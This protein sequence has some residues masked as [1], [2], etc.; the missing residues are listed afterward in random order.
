MAAISQMSIGPGAFD[1]FLYAPV[2]EDKAGID[3]T[4]LSA[5]A[6][7][8]LDPWSEAARLAEL[9]RAAAIQALTRSIALLPLGNWREADF[10]EIAARLVGRLPAAGTSLIA[11]PPNQASA[12]IGLARLIARLKLPPMSQLELKPAFWLILAIMAIGWF[13]VL[14]TFES[15]PPFEPATKFTQQ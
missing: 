8:G 6:R 5:L 1:A 13:Y 11:A 14:N 7:L 15:A 2:G 3:L 12:Q 4:V 9:P 10:P